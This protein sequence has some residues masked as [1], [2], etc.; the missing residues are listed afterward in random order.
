MIRRILISVA[1]AIGA[2]AMAM[3]AVQTAL[4]PCG[5]APCTNSTSVVLADDEDWDDDAEWDDDGDYYDDGPGPWLS[6]CA[7]YDTGIPWL[8]VG[9]CTNNLV[10]P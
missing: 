3:P 9:A 4:A 5:W 7:G 10:T 1:L 2:A 6:L 8:G